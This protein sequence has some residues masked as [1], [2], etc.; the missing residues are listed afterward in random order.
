MRNEKLTNYKTD[1][2]HDTLQSVTLFKDKNHQ[3]LH[4]HFVHSVMNMH[5]TSIEYVLVY[6]LNLDNK[7][8]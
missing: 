1:K 5:N 7:N 8:I 4:Y 6:T 2:Y 3:N